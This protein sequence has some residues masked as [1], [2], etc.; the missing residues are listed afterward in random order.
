[1][2]NIEHRTYDEKCDRQAVRD[3]LDKY[4][5]YE[6]RGEGCT[7]L[8]N[9][10]RWI[11]KAGIQSD[12]DAACKYLELYDRHNYDNLAVRYY[13]FREPD[14]SKKIAELKD[15]IKA[16]WDKYNGLDKQIWPQTLSSD[17]V[18]CKVCGSKLKREYLRSNYCPVCRQDMR[19]VSTINRLLS[20]KTSHDKAMDALEEYKKA[21]GKKLV[22]WLLKF[23]YHT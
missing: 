15:R 18:G 20:L 2:H 5:A 22:K 23:E 21:H 13:E 17:Y 1:M 16:S 8:Y 12:Y 11:E 4:V 19:P 7:G 10:I 6:D 9:P 14:N 3:A